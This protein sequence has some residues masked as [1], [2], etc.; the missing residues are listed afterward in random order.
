[1]NYSPKHND[2]KMRAVYGFL[3]VLGLALNFV[4]TGLVKTVASA[5]SLILLAV[6]LYFFVKHDMTTYTYILMENEGRVDFYIDRVVGKRGAYVCYYPLSDTV[7]AEKYEK[8][9][10]DKVNREYGKVFIYNYTH[11]RFCGDKQILVFKNEGYY[12]AVIVELSRECFDYIQK[13]CATENE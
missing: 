11:N 9:T 2:I 5:L 10:R 7:L 8:G 12:D 3:I 13:S 4:G 6:G 1:M